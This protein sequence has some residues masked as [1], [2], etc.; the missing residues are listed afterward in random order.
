MTDANSPKTVLIAE[1]EPDLRDLL[2]CAVDINGYN[3]VEASDGEE[4]YD[5]VKSGVVDLALV[6]QRM[7]PKSGFDF[8]LDLRIDGIDLPIIL[9]T[10]DTSNDLLVKASGYKNIVRVIKKPFDLSEVSE[11]VKR[12]LDRKSA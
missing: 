11:T 1:D 2:R 7:Q 8:A 10:G 9:I 6:D 4:A 3:V 12:T 5:I